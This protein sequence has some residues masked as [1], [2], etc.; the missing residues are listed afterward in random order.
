ME[1]PFMSALV[2]LILSASAAG[3]FAQATPVSNLVLNGNFASVTSGKPDKWQAAGEPKDVDMVLKATKDEEGKPC[4][5]LICTRCDAKGPASHAMLCQMG[6]ATLAAGRTYE[7]SCRMRAENLKSRSVGVA[8]AETNGWQNIGLDR[9]VPVSR[10]WKEYR[11]VFRASRDVGATGRLQMWFTE[12][13]TLWVSGVRICEVPQGEVEFTD[14]IPDARGRNLLPNGSFELGASGWSSLGETEV[15]SSG[16]SALHGVV[17]TSGGPQGGPFLRIPLGGDETPTVSFDYFTPFVHREIR[18]LAANL[19]WI[20]VVEGAPYTLSCDMRASK[21]GVRAMLGARAQNPAAGWNDYRKNVLLTTEWKRYSYTFKPDR[22]YVFVMVGPDLVAEDRVDVDVAAVQLEKGDQP[23]AWRPRKP[24]EFAIEPSQLT[25]IFTEGQPATLIVRAASYSETAVQAVVRFTVTNFYD[26]PAA[27]PGVPLTVPP[28]DTARVEVKLPAEWKGYYRVRASLDDP[29]EPKIADL[30]IAVVPK[31]TSG[32]SVC[33]INHAFCT[34]RLI[35]LASKAGITWFRDWSLKWQHLEPAKGEFHWEVGD[36]QIDR[37]LRTGCHVLPLLPPFPSAEWSSEAPAGPLAEPGEE[38]RLAR[39]ACAPKDPLE[40]GNFVE[41]AV[42]HYKDRIRIYEFLNEPVY[43]TY[44]LPE[45]LPNKG[46][47][48]T[49]AD[50]VAL[51]QVVAPAM[52]SADPT[53]RII[54]GIAGGPATY[55]REVIGA[56]CL[57]H[58]DYFNLHIYPGARR[59]EGYI[60]QMDALLELMDANGGRKPIWITEF[61]YYATDDLPRK[62]FIPRPEVWTE[63]NLLDN[64]RQCAELTVRFFAV[65]LSHGVRKIFVHSGATGRPNEPEFESAFFD[66]GGA[67]RRLF[68]AMAVL[69]EL[70][71]SDPVSAGYRPLSDAGH[72]AAFETG[73]Q[74]VLILWGDEEAAN[75]ILSGISERLRCLDLMGR[76][77]TARPLKLASAPVYLIGPAGEAKAFLDSL[78]LALSNGE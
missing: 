61:S 48:Y 33:G 10:L 56:G 64:E 49:P 52:K 43:T 39:Q 37:V 13:G 29:A 65:M 66:Y 9:T 28:N 50:Y 23:T 21:D 30:R 34:S 58:A 5:Q 77:V 3:T 73:K 19:G 32:D 53:C 4:A 75:S 78:E 42:A 41:K 22:R 36:A 71:G 63:P 1:T 69:T 6:G 20:K 45:N 14:V 67:P 24:V 68:P 57:K 12:P 27:L 35:E 74:S 31:R 54:A 76:E 55:T 18:P 62:P 25:G 8:F 72:A 40:L 51:L 15:W 60:P 59:P 44:A 46:K 38:G 2:V 11:L 16:L 70:L 17:E 26:Q 7:F 47:K